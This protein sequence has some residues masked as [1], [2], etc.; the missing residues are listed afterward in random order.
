VSEQILCAIVGAWGVHD[1]LFFTL[2]KRGVT[3]L[4]EVEFCGLNV[5]YNTETKSTRSI[6]G[7]SEEKCFER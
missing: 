1:T 7:S 3:K 2:C 4:R 6:D 5:L